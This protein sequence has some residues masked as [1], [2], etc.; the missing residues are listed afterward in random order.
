MKNLKLIYKL[1]IQLGIIF[2]VVLF[3]AY[4]SVTSTMTLD[5]RFANFETTAYETSISIGEIRKQLQVQE[6]L[7]FD[8]L[9]TGQV[10]AGSASEESVNFVME[11]LTTISEVSMNSEVTAATEAV[12]NSIFAT[13][14]VVEEMNALLSGG[15]FEAASN[16]FASDFQT[17]FAKIV[18]AVDILAVK[19]EEIGHAAFASVATYSNSTVITFYIIGA[20][21]IIIIIVMGILITRMITKPL[22]KF[23][24][25]MD[26]FAA[27]DFENATVDIDS[28]DEFGQLA[29][30]INSSIGT[31]KGL[32]EDLTGGFAALAANNYAVTVED[33]KDMYIGDFASIH[34]NIGVFLTNI[35]TALKQ[36]S[37]SANQVSA[38]TEQLSSGAQALAQGATEQASSVYELVST[39]TDLSAKITETANKSQES[40]NVST[41]ASGA[42]DASNE[43][44]SQLMESM[45]EIDAKSKEIS[46]IIKTIE[47]IAFQTNILALNAAVEAARAGS[48]GKGFAVVADEV[49]NLA[50]KSAE[51][52]SDTTALIEASIAAINKG[53]VL[54][55]ETSDNLGLVVEG[56]KSA[57]G[58][59]LEISQEARDQATA[60]EQALTGLDQISAVV[61]SNSATSEE[62]AAASEELS[63]QATMLRQLVSKFKLA[64]DDSSSYTAPAPSISDDSPL[65]FDDDFDLAIDENFDKY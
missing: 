46:K 35:N 2:L 56:S 9:I 49:R 30:N 42:V 10:Q 22:K 41:K 19:T 65:D 40:A 45:N 64:G 27:A 13:V 60:I 54:A 11:R 33:K 3:M 16:I 63:S 4:S 29:D 20:L 32:V 57:T 51:A 7:V 48:A 52:A 50:G 12:S 14:A 17:E 43:K 37:N 31:I 23:G 39:M 24:L 53:V 36:V 6:G 18:D 26:S 44:M 34:A 61:Q 25:A 38:G 62:S 59:S 15:D 1:S 8:S 5:G 21:A 55:Q 58:V 28:K 47:D